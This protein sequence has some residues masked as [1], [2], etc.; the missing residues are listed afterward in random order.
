M[1]DH[2]FFNFTTVLESV[3]PRI[4][5]LV[6]YLLPGAKKQAGSYRCGDATG[7]KGSSFSIS[8]RSNNAGTFLDHSDPSVKG[9]AI[10]LWAIVRGC[11]YDEAGAALAGFLGVMPETRL[12]TPKKRPEPKIT[13]VQ[14]AGKP[15]LTTFQLG[16]GSTETVRPLNK[17]SIEY[18]ASRGISHETLKLTRCAS[19]E[20]HIIFPHFDEEDK[21]VLL[22]C[23]SCDGKKNMFSNMDPVPVLF[24]KHLIDPLKTGATLVICEGQWDALSWIQLGY[25]A[26]SI[27]SGA[28]NDEWIGEDWNFLNRFSE[29]YL[30]FD[31]DEVGREAEARVRGR[32]GFERCRRIHYRFKDANDALKAGEPQVLREAFKAAQEAP[33]ERIV[34][35][36]DIKSKV[37]E[38]L[39][40]T[41]IQG[42]TPFFLP[43]L[44]LEFRPNEITVWVGTTSHGKST[45]LSNQVCYGA[46]LGNSGFVA[47]FEQATPMTVAAML[48]QY[49]S[50]PD[51]G[52]TSNFD[53]AY[54]SLTS[55]VMFFDSMNQAN[56][57]ELI[58][59]MIMA[60]KQLGVTEFVVDNIMTL[61][62]D[63]QDN[64]AQALVADKF[65]VFAA[66]YPIHLHLVAHPR[67]PNANDAPKPPGTADI[68]GASEWS[69]MAHNII[70]VWR[71]MAKAAQL[72]EMYD[73]GMSPADIMAYDNSLPDG[74]VLVRKQRDSGELPMTSYRFD[75]RSKRA[76]KNLEDAA[77]YWQAKEPTNDP[78]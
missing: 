56:P 14:E 78:T 77:P 28:S 38:R 52:Q 60:H 40:R 33:I 44:P 55:H 67:K 51:I 58:A 62:V 5:E 8:T 66:L 76:W 2:T 24:G 45:V 57:D 3:Y 72:S 18:A 19:T 25:P 31:D 12:Y 39:N 64:T 20:T 47:S 46:S 4:D 15:A 48:A 22:K 65:R 1:T 53:E 32:L 69:A 29:I 35:A 63:R 21:I 7:S 49:T 68:M 36:S 75:R 9:N 30:D 37:R 13:R 11:S 61:N 23:W 54:D 10:G 16:G 27:P 26:V 70:V 42:G 73:Q 71:D 74:K 41:H 34:K 50:D 6:N 59:T 43:S 17:R